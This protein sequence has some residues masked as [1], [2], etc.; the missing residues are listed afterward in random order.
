MRPADHPRMR[1]G[2]TIFA[3]AVLLS[4]F[5]PSV[6]AQG[7]GPRVSVRP[8]PMRPAIRPVRT[9]QVVTTA[10]TTNVNTVF[11]PLNTFFTIDDLLNGFPTPGLG[12]DF[13]HQA[14]INRGLG[15][16][17]LIDPVTQHQLALIR[18]IRRETPVGTGFFPGFFSSSPVIL[19]EPA[20]VVVPQPVVV[21]TELLDRSRAT[22]VEPRTEPQRPVEPVREAGEFVLVRRD[23]GLLFAVAFTTGPER[24]TY[25]TKDGVRRSLPL[26]DLDV[27]ATERINEERGT[28]LQLPGSLS[29]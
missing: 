20:V 21:Q 16:R 18:A 8:V 17:A 25:I 29:R 4:F 7:R 13:V 3:A 26:A 15:V 14:A 23:A 27:Q 22:E 1:A 24:I 28:P 5:A 12:F 19:V 11:Q 6:R 10:G 2:A 9:Q